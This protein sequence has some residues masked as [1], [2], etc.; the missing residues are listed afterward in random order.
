ME[1]MA[2]L[3]SCFEGVTVILHLVE[4][5]STYA[6]MFRTKTHIGSIRR[7]FSI[8]CVII[9]LFLGTCTLFVQPN[10]LRGTICCLNYFNGSHDQ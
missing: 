7:A 9:G 5:N 3:K 4:E 10:A 2:C 6:L 1:N 8:L